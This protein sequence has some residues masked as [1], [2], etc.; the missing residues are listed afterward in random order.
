MAKENGGIIGVVNTPTANTASGVWALEDQYNARVS[1]IWPVAPISIDFLVVAGG[2]GGSTF[3]AGSPGSGGAGGGG[4][5]ATG[6]AG[7]AGAVNTG[8]GGGGASHPPAGGGSGGKGV[9]IL[10]VPTANYSSTTTGSPTVSTSGAN[11][12]MVFNGSGS[13]T[14]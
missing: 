4:N 14:A 13:Y 3:S 10:S 8:S 1:N 11:T 12:I 5:G 7:S 2:G 9:V 6:S